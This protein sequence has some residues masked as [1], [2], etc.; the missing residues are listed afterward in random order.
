MMAKRANDLELEDFTYDDDGLPVPVP[1]NPRTRNSFS[2]ALATNNNND[3]IHSRRKSEGST[4]RRR[5]GDADDNKPKSKSRH[6]N[7]GNK[8]YQDH[9][10]VNDIFNTSSSTLPDVE[11]IR[12]DSEPVRKPRESP[13][14]LVQ[15]R[16][17]EDGMDDEIACLTLP[18]ERGPGKKRGHRSPKG[19][20][21]PPAVE[22]TPQLRPHKYTD[23]GEDWEGDLQAM[24][25]IDGEGFDVRLTSTKLILSPMSSGIHLMY[26]PFAVC[27]KVCHNLRMVLVGR[28]YFKP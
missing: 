5:E 2:S 21:E 16:P 22:R 20:N 24:F 15:S 19:Q 8:R 26:T 27:G 23:V 13:E 17:L 3:N 1:A 12:I 14:I 18:P 28:S 9:S 7:H 25:D 11:T 4:G 10:P 6:R